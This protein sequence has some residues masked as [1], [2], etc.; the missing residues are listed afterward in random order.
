MNTQKGLDMDA[1]TPKT[2]AEGIKDVF[3]I[4]NIRNEVKSSTGYLEDRFLEA[5]DAFSQEDLCII[6]ASFL[7]LHETC[8]K[9]EAIENLHRRKNAPMPVYI[10]SIQ[11]RP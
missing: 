11:E 8:L 9:L 7:A 2:T 3:D 6:Q 1:S 5:K 4:P 10:L